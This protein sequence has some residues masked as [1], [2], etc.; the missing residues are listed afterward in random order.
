MKLR[1]LQKATQSWTRKIKQ[2]RS[3]EPKEP[4]PREDVTKTSSNDASV[5]PSPDTITLDESSDI[6][7]GGPSAM[8][9]LVSE[10]PFYEEETLPREND[11]KL[12]LEFKLFPKLPIEL[13]NKIWTHACFIPR[14]VEL[15][16]WNYG[17]RIAIP[18]L[19]NNEENPWQVWIYR[20]NT[21]PPAVLSACAESRMIGL[22]HYRLE[23][24][25]HYA[26]RGFTFTT[27]STVFV[28]WGSD[29]IV[30]TQR[31]H[32]RDIEDCID[33]LDRCSHKAKF[34]ALNVKDKGWNRECDYI[35]PFL[36]EVIEDQGQMTLED[37]ILFSKENS[38]DWPGRRIDFKMPPKGWKKSENDCLVV[39][40]KTRDWAKKNLFS[41]AQDGA[42]KNPARIR[43]RHLHEGSG[44]Y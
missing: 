24:G 10:F 4:P 25:T 39:L 1:R 15:K 5:T 20:S 38:T 42:M 32:S 21:I 16:S 17:K 28:N 34:I 36:K 31:F 11:D 35:R 7:S 37:I 29:R 41:T 14:C 12:S 2:I 40:M 30:M 18:T 27:P 44:R 6:A 23:W 43:F 8:D 9:V 3:R 19:D 13:R 33:F 22:K 26:F